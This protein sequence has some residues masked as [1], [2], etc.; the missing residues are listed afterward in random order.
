VRIAV[1]GCGSIG[2][3]HVRNL[4]TL[5]I[6]DV[7]VFDPLA[8]RVDSAVALGAVAAPDLAALLASGPAA[9]L[10]C[11]PAVAHLEGMR[12]AAAANVDVF[13][14]KPISQDLAGVR[15]VLTE[16]ESAGRIVQV[17]FSLRSHRALRRAKQSLDEGAIGRVLLARAEFGQY[18][19]DWRPTRDY[20]HGYNAHAALGGGVLLDQSHELDYLR[21]MLGEVS[22]V[23]AR[24]GKLSDLEIDA[25][26]VAVVLL[27]LR[28]GALAI[29]QL[30]S[31][32][33]DYTR[34]CTLIGTKGTI[35][36][37]FTEGARLF[38][39]GSGWRELDSAPDANDMYMEEVR[40]FLDSV[41][42][43]SRPDVDGEAGL[44]ALELALAAK[45]SA[46][47]RREVAL[48]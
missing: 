1:A 39:P 35:V 41:R 25:E 26:D 15:E 10:I 43:R 3:R 42:S 27:E 11:T 45:R 32:R 46:R 21:W 37:S 40:G 6:D 24:A 33:R 9:L 12:A 2:L 34:T 17:G 36:W 28:S 18:L 47:E 7:R 23:S 44:R 20:R 19:P 14:E 4:L 31:V 22:S 38:T 5:D 48:S 16:L 8:D 30:D 29:A 13:V